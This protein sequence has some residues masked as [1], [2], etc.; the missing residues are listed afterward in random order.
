LLR[1]IE[2]IGDDAFRVNLRQ[3]ERDLL[4]SLVPQLRSLIDGRDPVAWRLFPNAYQDDLEKAAQYEDMVGNDLKRKRL[5]ALATLEG[6]VDETTLTE[7]QLLA[8]MGAINDLRLV[9]G[10]RLDVDEESEYE[11][12][13]DEIDRALFAAYMVLG[14]LME[15]IVAAL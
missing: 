1:T 4:R 8:W 6:T 12:F 13:A 5:R 2:R 11:D 14:W 10:T 9:L 15:N 3:D 7:A